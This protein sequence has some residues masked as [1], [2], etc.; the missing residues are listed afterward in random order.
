LD[1]QTEVIITGKDLVSQFKLAYPEKQYLTVIKLMDSS[2]YDKRVETKEELQRLIRSYVFVEKITNPLQMEIELK[3]YLL[4]KKNW[5]SPRNWNPNEIATYTGRESIGVKIPSVLYFYLADK[6]NDLI[7][8]CIYIMATDKYYFTTVGKLTE[9]AEKKNCRFVD[10]YG[11]DV[12]GVPQNIFRE[13]MMNEK[14]KK[15]I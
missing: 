10:Q 2:Q 14:I 9:W 4:M 3:T 13:G 1:E 7:N 5:V 15:E 8:F 12:I 11:G 6:H